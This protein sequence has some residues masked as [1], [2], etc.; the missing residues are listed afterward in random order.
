[1]VKDFT[2]FCQLWNYGSLGASNRL[3]DYEKMEAL[4]TPGNQPFSI[5]QVSTNDVPG[6]VA[7]QIIRILEAISG[8][9]LS[10]LCE[11]IVGGEIFS[12]RGEQKHEYALLHYSTIK[13]K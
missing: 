13:G 1:M 11:T 7:T 3:Q 2:N 10:A 8:D 9:K 4:H 12:C 6:F 5:T